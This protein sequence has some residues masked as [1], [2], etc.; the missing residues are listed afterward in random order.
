MGVKD[1][2]ASLEEHSVTFSGT[3]VQGTSVSNADGTLTS[4]R[5]QGGY[6]VRIE[7]GSSLTN[8]TGIGSAAFQSN[9]INSQ[10]YFAATAGS[11]GTVLAVNAGSTVAMVQGAAGRNVSGVDFAGNASTPYYWVAIGL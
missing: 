5:S 1:G 9:F 4:S 6:G 11:N 8:A 7:T 3:T 10:Y 2:L